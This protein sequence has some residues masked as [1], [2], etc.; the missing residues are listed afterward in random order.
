MT[1]GATTAGRPRPIEA[2]VCCANIAP[3]ASSSSLNWRS[4][5]IS[6][7]TAH[8]LAGQGAGRLAMPVGDG[9]GD[10]GGVVAAY[11]LHQPPP[12]TRQVV[13]H[14]RAVQRQRLPV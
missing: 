2:K 1:A 12:A 6:G 14:A 9:A 7:G 3:S 11:R 4:I 10:D 13:A 8:Q 5:A